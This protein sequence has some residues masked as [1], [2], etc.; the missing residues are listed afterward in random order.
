[1][2][3]IRSRWSRKN[4]RSRC[5]RTR[6]ARAGKPLRA[7]A[8]HSR[9]QG[10]LRTAGRN[11]GNATSRACGRL[12]A[13]DGDF[14]DPRR[15][16]V[17]R[18]DFKQRIETF[19]N[20][21]KAIDKEKATLIGWGFRLVH[22]SQDESGD[23]SES[24]ARAFARAVELQIAILAVARALSTHSDQRSRCYR[25]RRSELMFSSAT[26]RPAAKAHRQR[27]RR[28]PRP[29]SFFSVAIHP[30]RHSKCRC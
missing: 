15:Q 19:L 22:V 11:L 27:P 20:S 29:R 17:S 16:P 9:T 30:R 7:G 18:T 6:S 1:M 2:P 21:K 5:R 25:G 28:S 23:V 26:S 24:V 12:A 10:W 3:T 13:L 8:R 4:A 14:R